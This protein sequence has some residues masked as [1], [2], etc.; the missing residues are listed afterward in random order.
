[1]KKR[2]VLLAVAPDKRY[3]SQVAWCAQKMGLVDEVRASDATM[4]SFTASLDAISKDDDVI[5]AKGM[6]ETTPF[7]RLCLGY[8]DKKLIKDGR[9]GFV[10]HCFVLEKFGIWPWRKRPRILTDAAVNIDPT[11]AQKARI[12]QNAVDFA[13]DI[14]GIKRPMISMLTAAGVWNPKIQSSIDALWVIESGG[15]ENADARLDQF[16]TAVSV[17]AR[18]VKKLAGG[19]ADIMLV[20][21]LD[22]GNPL[23]KAHTIHGGFRAAG[24]VL[25]FT[26]PVVLN[27]RF[28]C[29]R[30]KLLSIKY[31]KKLI[32]KA[33]LSAG[34]SAKA[35]AAAK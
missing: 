11:P 29:A 12:A 8:G 19:P 5:I 24:L 1:M 21:D 33:S 16:D 34:A 9:D 28:D 14:L 26:V 2:I 4:E 31:A 27:S 25:G 15:L 22:A 3:M 6:V 23:L 35:D 30:S 18:R 13:R 7:M 10:S 20:P 17:A 32:E